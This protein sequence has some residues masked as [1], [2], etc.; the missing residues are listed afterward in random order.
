MGLAR[1]VLERQLTRAEARLADCEKR[2]AAAG[3]SKDDLAGHPAW[4][5][6]SAARRQIKRRLLSSDAWHSRGAAAGEGDE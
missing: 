2:L 6:S 1:D 4:R 3:V 5:R